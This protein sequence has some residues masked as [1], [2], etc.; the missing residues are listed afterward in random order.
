MNMSLPANNLSKEALKVKTELF[1]WKL[2][3]QNY[4]IQVDPYYI[5]A[6]RA[7]KVSD[8]IVGL[9]RDAIE[10][11]SNDKWEEIS[12]LFHGELLENQQSYAAANLLIADPRDPEALLI[13]RESIKK[14]QPWLVFLEVNQICNLKCNFCYV[15]ML[16]RM[17]AKDEAIYTA[18]DKITDSGA[19]FLGITG[20]E[21]S[22]NKNIVSIIKY[23]IRKGIAVT[24]RT[25]L[26]KLPPDI[27]LL[28]NEPRLVLITSIHHG[29]ESEFDRI[30]G[31]A[32]SKQNIY[33]NIQKLIKLNIRVRAHIV[34][35]SDN[36]DSLD[37]MIE[38]LERTG[39]P[40]TMT[41]HVMPYSGQKGNIAEKPLQ[42]KLKA[43]LTRKLI[44][45]GLI[46]RQRNTCT[47]AQSKIWI[48]ATGDVFPCELFRERPIGNF[49]NHSIKDILHS[50]EV[51]DWRENH[52]Y[53]SE[54]SGCLSCSARSG[55]PRCPAMIEIEKGTSHS[56]HDLTCFV[57]SEIFNLS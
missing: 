20:G 14:I 27:E 18:I 37:Q 17:V 32:G 30:V 24:V 4:V 44:E 5:K 13:E 50:K 45:R 28:A 16:P 8:N 15:D 29:D 34:V 22:L 21:P 38:D 36:Y 40:F 43:E 33:N 9:F 41:D 6:R 57:T 35:K 55:C 25:N 53:T 39:V 31:K 52:I 42:Y 48:S 46:E 12:E 11:D 23:A 10:T 3:N 56:K 51:T 47:A 7:W 19:M 1:T 2:D 49:S 54:Q 26:L